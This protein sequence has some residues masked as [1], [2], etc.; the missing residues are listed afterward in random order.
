MPHLKDSYI[1]DWIEL[2]NGEEL[3]FSISDTE[4][5]V[6]KQNKSPHAM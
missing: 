6:S 3:L 1:S 4:W 5:V 2:Y